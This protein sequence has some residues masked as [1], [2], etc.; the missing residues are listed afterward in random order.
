M[1]KMDKPGFRIATALTVLCYAAGVAVFFMR[2]IVLPCKVA[3]PAAVLALSVAATRRRTLV[4]F[5]FAFLASALGDAAGAQGAFIRQMC[6]FGA[7]HAAF[8]GYFF[9]RGTCR[10]RLR[11]AL[12]AAALFGIM[13]GCLAPGIADPAER[14][15]ALFYGT[16]LAGMFYGAWCQNGPGAG[17][18]RLAAL[19]F[20]VSDGMIAW[21][22]FVAPFPWRTYAVMGTY[23]LAQWLLYRAALRAERV[24][25]AV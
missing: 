3:Y 20:V 15:G 16:L 11:P 12:V 25:D 19:S 17:L 21:S 7:A 10:L 6:W 13:L 18:F 14:T 4:P 2:T 1:S 23:Y 5:C 22:R 9:T 24:T 8:I